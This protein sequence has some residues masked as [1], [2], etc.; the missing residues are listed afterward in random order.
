[1]N[2]N[3]IRR[4]FTGCE[5]VTIKRYRITPDLKYTIKYIIFI[6]IQLIFFRY[7]FVIHRTTRDAMRNLQRPIDFH[8]FGLE[9]RVEYARNYSN[10][11]HDQQNFDQK[12]IVVSHIPLN[13]YERDLQNLFV[14]CRVIEFC[15]ARTIHPATTTAR[16]EDKSKILRG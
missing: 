8:I 7:A 13:V 12:K 1:M 4:H 9:C 16:A 5:K 3:D 11:P 15:P 10:L 6:L 2:V 14:N